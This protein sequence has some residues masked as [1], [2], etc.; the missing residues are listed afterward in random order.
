M[1][2]LSTGWTQEMKTPSDSICCIHPGLTSLLPLFIH[3]DVSLAR[4]GLFDLR[5]GE[6]GTQQP[7]CRLQ[8]GFTREGR[9]AGGSTA[10][11]PSLHAQDAS[12]AVSRPHSFLP[13][14][15]F[16]PYPRLIHRLIPF[17]PEDLHIRS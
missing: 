15:L 13:H 3:R 7:L 10:A 16:Y 11:G 2:R 14:R 4:V 6:D 1:R 9:G 5:K 12:F 8:G 17:I